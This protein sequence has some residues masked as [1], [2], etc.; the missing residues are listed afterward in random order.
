MRPRRLLSFF[1]LM[2]ALAAGA[3]ATSQNVATGAQLNVQLQVDNNL[4]GITGTSVYLMTEAGSR[5]SLGPV[6]SNRRVS[7]DRELRAGTYFLLA[8]QVGDTDITSER[9]RI[10]TDGTVVMWNLSANQ[11][12]FG[13]K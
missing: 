8:T 12:A 7:F 9:F 5:R 2:L 6:E 11:L 4:P 3:C 13:Q 10:D 1:V